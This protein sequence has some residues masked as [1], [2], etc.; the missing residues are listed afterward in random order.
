[1]ATPYS[2]PGRLDPMSESPRRSLHTTGEFNEMYAGTPPWDIG[3]P[4]PAFQVLADAGVLRGRVL[5]IGCGT[6]EH[7]LMAAQSGLEAVGIDSSSAAIEIAKRKAQ[8]RGL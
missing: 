8:E 6:G 1:M 7:A 3:R 5:D 2:C 4:Q